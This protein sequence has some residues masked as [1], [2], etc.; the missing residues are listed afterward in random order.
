VVLPTTFEKVERAL[1]VDFTIGKRSFDGGTDTSQRCEMNHQINRLLLE[2]AL[3][4]L[5]LTHI[6]LPA[7]DASSCPHHGEQPMDIRLFHSRSIKI[8][9]IIQACHS[10]PL[11]SQMSTQVR[12]NKPC[13][14]CYKNVRHYDI[15]LKGSYR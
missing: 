12:P 13:S 14:S 8:I 15:R 11:C 5:V 1:D 4:Q 6:A 10:V 9:E 2:E 7:Y 3:Q